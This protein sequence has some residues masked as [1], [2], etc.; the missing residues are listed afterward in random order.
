MTHTTN[1]E[2][3]AGLHRLVGTMKAIKRSDYNAKG[4]A[5]C[6]LGFMLLAL[7]LRV[8]VVKTDTSDYISFLRPWVEF[9]KLHGIDS[10]RYNF[11]NYNTPYLIL[12][13]VGTL[14]RLPDLVIVKGI[15]IVF[16]FVLAYSVYLIVGYFKKTGVTKLLAAIATLFLPTV[17]INSALWGQCDAIYTAFI[18]FAL[19]ACLRDRSN[20]AWLLWGVAFAF[21]LQAVFFLPLLVYVHLSRRWRIVGPLIFLAIFGSLSLILPTIEGRPIISTLEI[22]LSQAQHA[23]SNVLSLNAPTFYQWL[24]NQYFT[25]LDRAGIILAAAVYA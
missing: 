9:L 16:D 4:L 7:V 24:P 6:F 21:K 1:H 12:L 17:F 22:Y 20:V 13:Y 5:L 11:A 14:L 25:Q 8:A 19:Y 15:S 23:G 3:H 18:L 10:F 2:S